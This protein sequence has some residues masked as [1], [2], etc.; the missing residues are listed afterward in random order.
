MGLQGAV[1]L[2]GRLLRQAMSPGKTT[3][4]KLV[5]GTCTWRFP[6]LIYGVGL[7]GQAAQG[8]RPCCCVVLWIP[9]GGA[10]LGVGKLR[11]L[12]ERLSLLIIM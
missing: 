4:V 6:L 9:A 5:G 2:V 11:R 7:V 10:A 1:Q 12:G 3:I 8:P